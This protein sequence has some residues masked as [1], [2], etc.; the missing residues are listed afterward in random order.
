MSKV[1]SS[2]SPEETFRMYGS[3]TRAQVE[4]LLERGT[5]L[6]SVNGIDAHLDEARCQ[7]PAE[8]FLEGHKESL[9]DL[10]E[11]LRGANRETL[12]GI[13]ENLADIATNTNNSADYGREELDKALKVIEGVRL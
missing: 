10:M 7:Y 6:E 1:F 11:N 5:A 13:I 2:M 9:L 12:K 8:D 3:L 4:C